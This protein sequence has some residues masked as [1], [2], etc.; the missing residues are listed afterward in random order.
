MNNE[1]H[2]DESSEQNAP[3]IIE[4]LDEQHLPHFVTTLKSAE[5]QIGENIIT[6]LQHD[7]T[8]AVLTTV[9]MGPD[10]NQRIVSAALNPRLMSQVQQMLAEAQREREDEEMCIGFHCLIKPRTPT[11]A[12]PSDAT[13]Q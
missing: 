7:D 9:I 5:Q 11:D 12:S 3:E 1:P 4:H 8:V 2:A 6:A 10:G 13:D